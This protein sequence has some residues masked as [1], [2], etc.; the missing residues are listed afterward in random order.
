MYLDAVKTHLRD[1]PDVYNQ[2]L[3]T[4]KDFK[5]ERVDTVGLC[6]QVSTLLQKD[7]HLM[8]G[9]STFLPSDYHFN[10]PAGGIEDR[11]IN[12]TAIEKIIL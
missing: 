1:K 10:S 5:N 2:F 6:D 7:P 4:M 3:G 12:W 8:E 11:K 9:F